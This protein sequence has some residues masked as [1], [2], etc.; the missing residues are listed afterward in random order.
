MI[1]ARTEGREL[2][3]PQPNTR[4]RPNA[5]RAARRKV[6]VPMAAFE[7][8]AA[9]TTSTAAGI[10]PETSALTSLSARCAMPW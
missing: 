6:Y 7:T 3:G 5:A 8:R 1:Q 4:R 2:T 10:V 9:Q